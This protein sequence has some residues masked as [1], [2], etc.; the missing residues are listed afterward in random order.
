[1]E[2]DADAV[3]FLHQESGRDDEQTRAEGRALKII[4]AKTASAPPANPTCAFSQRVN[5]LSKCPKEK[6]APVNPWRP[7]RTSAP[8]SFMMKPP[9]TPKIYSARGLPWRQPSYQQRGPSP[10]I[11]T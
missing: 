6:T 3:I 7:Q 9:A 10:L 1:M 4:V 11:K 8:R 5:A 2:Q